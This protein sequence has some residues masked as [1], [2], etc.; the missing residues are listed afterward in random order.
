MNKYLSDKL[1]IISLISM[2]M[3]VFLHSY[4]ITMKFN[5]GNISFDNKYN[6]FIQKFFSEGI[7]RI[8]VPIFFCISGYLFFL[9]FKGTIHEFVLKYK[10]RVKSLLL[11]YL[12]WSIWG[13]LFYFCL[14]TIP[15]SKKFFTHELIIN[16]SFDKILNTIFIDPIPYQL[17]FIR[18]LI[19]LVVISPLLYWIT[20]VFR[21][22]P[23]IILFIIWLDFFSFSFLIF[24]NEAILFF[25][26][27]IYFSVFKSEY[28]QT[29]YN[30]KAYLGF[31][32]LWIIIVF[33]KT[34][35]IFH[36][37]DKIVLL[38]LLHKIGIV[39][40]ILAIWSFYDILLVKNTPNKII[41]NLSAFSFFLYAFHEPILT[42]MKKGLFYTLGINEIT[43]NIIYFIAPILTI[44]LGFL[45][46]GFL[47]KY[48]SL[49]YNLITGSR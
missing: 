8:A 28:L 1:K 35:L 4:N 34:I 36:N 19:V 2:I 41:L 16:Y 9:N 32:L 45:L 38:S 48:V 30:R 22:L 49:F 17:W 27:G 20:K 3:V 44:I 21:F 13:L 7:T 39:F 25:C 43:S 14:Q 47:K 5:P 15:Q 46:G 23:I 26:L 6:I 12:L 37:P 29:K 33:L 11:P 18:D 40:G 31:F 10:K 24:S 42:I